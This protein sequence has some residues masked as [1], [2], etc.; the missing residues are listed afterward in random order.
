[1][2][3][4]KLKKNLL[5]S[6]VEVKELIDKMVSDENLSTK[7]NKSAILEDLILNGLMTKNNYVNNWIKYLYTEE[8]TIR[9]IIQNILKYNSTGLDGKSRGITLLKIVQFVSFLD[10]ASDSKIDYTKTQEILYE[11]NN[12]KTYCE[13]RYEKENESNKEY[14]MIISS[15]DF[16]CKEVGCDK[17]II[18]VNDFY[19]LVITYWKWLK[20]STYTFR[21]LEVYVSL[22]KDYDMTPKLRYEFLN[23]LRDLA[24]HW[25]DKSEI[26][27]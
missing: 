26:N 4:N 23:I 13:E 17:K 2:S 9:E 19:N 18:K 25:D 6:S 10:T 20:D 24:K 12:L 7:R 5:F 1:M 8:H 16:I 22:K 14:K 3:D 21:A 15:L 11:L 27:F